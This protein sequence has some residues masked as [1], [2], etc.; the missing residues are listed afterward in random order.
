M[1]ISLYRIRKAVFFWE[2]PEIY[3]ISY[4]KT[5]RTWLR[6]LIGK[7]LSLT[8]N[9]PEKRILNT[10]YMSMAAHLPHTVV[11]HDGAEML[12]RKN[13]REL[14]TDKTQYK[15]KK[16][17]IL[18]RDVRDTLVSAYFQA[19]KRIKVFEGTISEFIRSEQFGAVKILTF[20]K[21]WYEARDV[22]KE[23]LFLRYEDLHTTPQTSLH[24]VL[25]FL[26]IPD[27]S[28]EVI[29]SAI[30]YASFDNLKKAEAE[31]RFSSTILSSTDGN[32]PQS[33]KVREGKVGKY[34]KYLNEEDVK[35][36]DNQ[37]ETFG[38]EFTRPV[39]H[40]S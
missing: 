9:L 35:Y 1:H 13:Y 17:I 18:S 30:E 27:P 24:S 2:K 21:Q 6:A 26:G 19:T 25:T 31:N 20:Y 12:A 23:F 28:A 36:I 29:Q 39:D 14:N 8:Y 32:D 3:L 4:P 40:N 22:P 38:C 11:T 15:N 37:I 33:S 34:S 16:V 10:E 7:S 5:G